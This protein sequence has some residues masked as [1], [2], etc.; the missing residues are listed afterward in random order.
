MRVFSPI[1]LHYLRPDENSE[2][3][4]TFRCRNCGSTRKTFAVSI[5]WKH[6]EPFGAIRKFGE[7]PPFGPPTAARVISLIGP[8]KEFYLTGR[9]AENQ[10][11]GIGAFAYYRRVVENQKNRILD[12]I[13][14]VAKRVAAPEDLI[15][16]LESAKQETQFSKAVAAVKH[17][18]PQTLLVNGHNS[19]TLLHNALS[20]GLHDQTDE[21]CLE[22]A[23]AIR[24]VLTEL[25]ERLG[26]AL[27]DQAELN[28]AVS[29]L[30]APKQPKGA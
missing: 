17:G 1:T 12:E 29:K 23:T 9:R 27:K 13:I 7:E 30:M 26:S 2:A 4:I 24:L 8:D 15:T 25:A 28:A 22:L 16:G 21:H 14:R 10:G 20:E 11:M 19:L 3:F 18:M 6:L 5:L